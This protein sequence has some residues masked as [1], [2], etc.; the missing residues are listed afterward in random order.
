MKLTTFNSKFTLIIFHNYYIIN[1]IMN[2]I[3]YY[4]KKYN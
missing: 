2:Y 1:Y 4:N 3:L